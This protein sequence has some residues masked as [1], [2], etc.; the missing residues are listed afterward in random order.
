[1]V[2][3]LLGLWVAM[4]CGYVVTTVMSLVAVLRSDWPSLVTAAQLRSEATLKVVP[5]ELDA[6]AD[7]A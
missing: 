3:A 6:V 7:G 4:I 1:V 2:Q 5:V